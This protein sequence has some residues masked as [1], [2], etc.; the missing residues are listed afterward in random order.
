MA[1]DI[2]WDELDA[3]VIR[4]RFSANWTWDDYRQSNA[5]VLRMAHRRITGEPSAQFPADYRRLR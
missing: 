5:E 1:I 4:A 2:W 3:T